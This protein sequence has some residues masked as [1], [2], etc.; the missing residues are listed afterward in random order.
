MMFNSSTG[1]MLGTIADPNGHPF[2]W[3]F[4]AQPAVLNGTV[5]IPAENRVDAF[6]LP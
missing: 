3:N 6:R 1:A 5:Y 4:Q 2:I